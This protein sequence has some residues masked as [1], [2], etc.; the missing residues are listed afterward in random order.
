LGKRGWCKVLIEGGAHLAGAALRAGMV[1]RV[2]FFVAPRIL[3][4]GLPA[5]AGLSAAT[6]RRAIRLERMSARTVGDDFLIEAE[7][8]R[9]RSRRAFPSVKCGDS[10]RHEA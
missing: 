8:C 1:D 2:A 5:I 3:G 9:I 7:V 6:M 10:I 4:D